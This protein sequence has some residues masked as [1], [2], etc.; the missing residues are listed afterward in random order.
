MQIR[1]PSVLVRRITFWL[2]VVAATIVAA[3]AWVKSDKEWQEAAPVRE[4]QEVEAQ[5]LCDDTLEAHYAHGKTGLDYQQHELDK[6]QAIFNDC[7]KA[8]RAWHIGKNGER[9]KL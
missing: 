5:K 4:R 7:L 1:N 9:I 2:P 3:M 8:G 6:L